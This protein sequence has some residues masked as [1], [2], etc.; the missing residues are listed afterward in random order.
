MAEIAPRDCFEHS[1]Q[2]IWEEVLGAAGIGIRTSFLAAG[3]NTEVAEIMLDRVNEM[4][5]A[6]VPLAAFLEEPTIERLAA[7]VDGE[8]VE[9][10]PPSYETFAPATGGTATA[11][12]LFLVSDGSARRLVRALGRRRQTHLLPWIAVDHP[13]LD[14]VE[15]TAAACLHTVRQ[16]QPRGPYRL[17]GFCLGASIAFEMACRLEREGETVEPLILLAPRPWSHQWFTR[18]FFSPIARLRRLDAEREVEAFAR[19]SV[20]VVR[21]EGQVDSYAG[22]ARRWLER[23]VSEKIGVVARKISR[24]F[25]RLARGSVT[26]TGAPGQM[27]PVHPAVAARRARH[28]QASV[29]SKRVNRAYIPGPYAGRITILW[30]EHDPC[31]RP[32]YPDGVW[33]EVARAVD[34]S[35]VRGGHHSCLTRHVESLADRMTQ[36][37]RLAQ[38][39]SDAASASESQRAV[40]PATS[41]AASVS[42]SA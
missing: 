32:G 10:L 17:A 16:L 42:S 18:R 34:L 23:P 13:T 41:A 15:A 38:D 29:V 2:E 20:R 35:I 19:L 30:P 1:L 9:S 36:C 31:N 12:G 21:W 8:L 3:G 14:S 37:L 33:R 25:R 27:T 28:R 24:G 22:R 11:S 5:D 4:L 6:R 26:P 40:Q 39:S 7:A